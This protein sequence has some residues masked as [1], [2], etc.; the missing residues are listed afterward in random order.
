MFLIIFARRQ[1]DQLQMDPREGRE[2]M[3]R[4]DEWLNNIVWPHVQN[5]LASTLPLPHSPSIHGSMSYDVHR[6]DSARRT[7]LRLGC[8]RGME[9]GSGLHR[10]AER[11]IQLGADPN[12]MDRE[13]CTPL[14]AMSR[15]PFPSFVAIK[16]LL[17]AG[18]DIC[19]QDK[20]GSTC[21][22]HLVGKRQFD[23]LQEMYTQLPHHM[24]KVDYTLKDRNG[25]TIIEKARW[26]VNGAPAW[27]KE[28]TKFK[29]RQIRQLIRSERAKL[30]DG[31]RTA[32]NDC[33]PLRL[34]DVSNLNN[35]IFSYAVA[36][37]VS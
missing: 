34:N 24:C 6:T 29:S 12:A 17:D 25:R 10:L 30:H 36:E 9:E 13:G 5:L 19:A 35:L 32:L 33:T 4:R 3:A 8:E 26:M 28:R 27:V 31:I 22:H 20:T 37:D 7:A 11:L 16:L 1:L 21:I 18:A 14:V 23:L 15:Y 2:L